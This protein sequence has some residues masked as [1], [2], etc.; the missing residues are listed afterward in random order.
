MHKTI[1]SDKDGA[2]IMI[3]QEIITTDREHSL[4]KYTV[5][6]GNGFSFSCL[7]YGAALTSITMPDK[8]GEISNILLSFDRPD[9]F[10]DDQTYFF[11]KPIGR[12]G[13]RICDGSCNIE[14]QNYQ[15]PQNE[16]KNTLHGGK[17]GFHHLW[18]DATEIENGIQFTKL[19]DSNV[20]SF[21]GTI[22]V[23][24][25]YKWDADNRIH[26][27]FKG[28]NQSDIATLFNPTLHSYFNLNNDKKNGLQFHEL[29]I[30]GDQ[31]VEMR[32]D[33][34]PTGKLLNVENTLFDFRSEQNLMNRI[35]SVKQAGLSGYDHPYKVSGPEVAV[36]RNSENGR[37][38]KIHSDRNALI[39]Y[40]LN[41]IDPEIVM[42][43]QNKLMQHMAVALEPQTL[44]DAIHHPEFGNIILPAKAEQTYHIMYE[45]A[46][47]K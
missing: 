8:N 32:D 18:W 20:D 47:E 43:D 31:V 44:P 4:I 28:L 42:N 36:L 25:T 39:C 26:I 45:L 30:H 24:I 9:D 29:T 2:N 33:L 37:V 22:E 27:D 6:N 21:P 35:D 23:T 17:N 16:G 41:F 13:G 38:L 7:N 19:I 15:L 1:K 40:S 11:G 5:S 14:G 3:D 46:V 10:I 34:I 12:V